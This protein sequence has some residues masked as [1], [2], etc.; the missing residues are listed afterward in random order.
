[1]ELEPEK[2]RWRRV[3]RDWYAEGVAGTPG[4]GKL[5]RPRLVRVP[6]PPLLSVMSLTSL[7][8]CYSHFRE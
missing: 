7:P 6:P 8:L 4:H 1:M 2:D 3:A 5:T